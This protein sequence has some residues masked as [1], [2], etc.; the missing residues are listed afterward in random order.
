MDII[1]IG[2]LAAFFALSWAFAAGCDRLG[3]K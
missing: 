1:Y 2:A 3:G